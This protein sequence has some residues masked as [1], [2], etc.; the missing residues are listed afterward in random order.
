MLET[1]KRQLNAFINV[2][3]DLKEW[4]HLQAML[5]VGSS[6]ARNSENAI[7]RYTLE[8]LPF[9]PVQYEDGT[10]SQVKDI[11]QV[12][13]IRRIPVRILKE[14]K[15]ID[16]NQYTLA[17]VIGTFKITSWLKLTTSFSR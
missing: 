5:N 11:I 12:R 17:N 3:W 7:S 14:R 6:N 10:Y 2:G 8:A 13:K 1:Y 15:N 4:F 9:L 16:K